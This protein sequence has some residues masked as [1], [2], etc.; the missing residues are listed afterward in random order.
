[1]DA[2]AAHLLD[3]TKPF[4]CTLLDQ[5]LLIAMDGNNPQ[6]QAANEF[7]VR[8]KEHPDMW[9]RVDAILESSTQLTTKIFGL[10]ILHIDALVLIV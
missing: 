6:R 2:A 4:D 8:I 10:Q 5:I 3:F 9:K 1:M 7:L